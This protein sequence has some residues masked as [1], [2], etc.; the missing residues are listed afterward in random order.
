MTPGN[1]MSLH[2]SIFPIALLSAL[3]VAAVPP[4]ALGGGPGKSRAPAGPR[5]SNDGHLAATRAAASEDCKPGAPPYGADYR[6][7]RDAWG[8][9][10]APAELPGGRSKRLPFPVEIAVGSETDTASGET[11]VG[12]GARVFVDPES[13]DRELDQ[14][15][16]CV[17]SVK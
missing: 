12:S 15:Q 16:D 14:T 8:Q 1:R 10:V 7:G 4:T 3:A 6:A 2:R 11:I 5:W 9:Q 13:L 17:P